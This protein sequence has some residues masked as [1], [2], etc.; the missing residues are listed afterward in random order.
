M[1][2]RRTLPSPSAAHVVIGARHG[3]P[4]FH[5]S[6]ADAFPDERFRAVEHHNAPGV[7]PAIARALRALLTPKGPTL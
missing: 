1:T 2:A 6:M 4:R 5:S 7:L 3:M